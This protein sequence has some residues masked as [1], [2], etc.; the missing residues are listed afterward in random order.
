MTELTDG[1]GELAQAYEYDAWGNATIYDPDETSIKNPYLYTGREWDVE[2]GLYYYRAR[3]YHPG[4]GRFIQPD[5]IGYG[6]KPNLYLYVRN[7]P[8]LWTDPSG[9]KG[10]VSADWMFNGVFFMSYGWVNPENGT[11]GMTDVEV[12]PTPTCKC[13]KDDPCCQSW[14]LGVSVTVFVGTNDW[15]GQTPNAVSLSTEL[16]N[17]HRTRLMFDWTVNYMETAA[18]IKHIKPEECKANCEAQQKAL[19]EYWL[20]E[21]VGD[22]GLGIWS[23][24]E[25]HEIELAGLP[26]AT[27]YKTP[28]ERYDGSIES[29]LKWWPTRTDT[30]TEVRVFGPDAESST[31]I[32][33]QS[34]TT[35]LVPAGA[36]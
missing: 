36:R 7:A 26:G 30:E 35:T 8:T 16:V 31:G 11:L 15:F 9:R 25:Q 22:P 29:L 13:P 5:P 4:L 10:E 14:V 20:I 24:I 27:P 34:R 21:V 2:I 19:R 6:D 33:L 18:S 12:K 3:H 23:Y 32:S 17:V 1:D 28:G